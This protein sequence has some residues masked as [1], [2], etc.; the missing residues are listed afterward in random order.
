MTHPPVEPTPD[1]SLL[2]SFFET[3]IVCSLSSGAEFSTLFALGTAIVDLS[4][5]S[6]A[7]SS[8]SSGNGVGGGLFFD[9]SSLSFLCEKSKIFEDLLDSERVLLPSTRIELPT[10]EKRTTVTPDTNLTPQHSM[11]FFN[12][13]TISWSTRG[14]IFLLTI[15]V[16]SIPRPP[17][18]PATSKASLPLPTINI[19]FPSKVGRD[20]M[21]STASVFSCSPI[22]Q[23][24]C[25]KDHSLR[26][27]NYF[28]GV[29]TIQKRF[30]ELPK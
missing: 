19:R 25:K 30:F 9:P 12:S 17:R 24:K 26:N 14:N 4:P 22:Y 13:S 6:L 16:V 3:S 21:S 5:A 23:R 7:T 29:I 28:Q 11:L 8:A 2:L 27:T 10:L 15:T 18:N 20:R 1:A